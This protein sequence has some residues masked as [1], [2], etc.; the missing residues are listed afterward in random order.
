MR[1]GVALLILLVQ[2]SFG[3][4]SETGATRS[5]VARYATKGG[6][7]KKPK[8]KQP[9]TSGMEWARS[10]VVM[11]YDSVPLRE[12]VTAALSA[13]DSKCGRTLDPS[14]TASGN[15]PKALWSA[16]VALVVVN[17]ERIEYVNEAATEALRT[18][19]NAT[20]ATHAE[21]VGAESPFPSSM[22]KAFESSYKKKVGDVMLPDVTRWT[23]DKMTLTDGNL[24]TVNLGVA[25]AFRQWQL[26]EGTICEPGGVR[27][28]PTPEPDQVEAMIAEQAAFVRR[29]KEVDGRTNKDPAVVEAVAELL[30]LKALL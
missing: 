3:F 19:L 14:L 12:L 27:K 4:V 1:G 30:R 13:H 22:P 7:K 20:N 18:A 24:G 26:P 2:P 6:K 11:P 15:P 23:V 8:K 17:E 16:P 10:F 25:Y 9:K 29:L 21:L 5:L 28:E